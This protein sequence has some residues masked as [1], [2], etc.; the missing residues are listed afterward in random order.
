MMAW[1][2]VLLGLALAASFLGRWHGIGDALAVI[3]LPLAVAFALVVIWS[4]WPAAL[5]WPLA[6]GA[7]AMIAQV[8]ALRFVPGPPGDV[9]VYQ[10]N[11]LFRN[12]APQ[13]VVDDILRVSP[14]IVT[15]QEVSE[16]NR[17]IPASLA[18]AYPT[19]ILCPYASVGGVAVLTRWPATGRTVC[20][21]GE[22]LTAIEVTGP[23]GPV[24]LASAHLH[25][26][27]PFGQHP[28]VQ[29][30]ALRLNDLDGPV[31]LAG[32]FNM[33]PWGWSVRALARAAGGQRVAG[34]QPT[35]WKRGV[36][37]PIDH[38]IAPR[39]GQSRLLGR[40]GSD[41]AG[42]LARVRVW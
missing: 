35:L 25:W 12:A 4:D 34:L 39:G 32:D 19:Q 22:G 23:G 29:R 11:L 10:K 42:V 40:L 38:V 37:L 8:V 3:R 6:V 20:A 7:L 41:H 31:V 28:Q 18:A 24:W 2:S 33:V 14:D 26:P 1:L 9:T 36:P 15:L 30:L 27:W 5:R 13:S 17:V 21:E 16:P